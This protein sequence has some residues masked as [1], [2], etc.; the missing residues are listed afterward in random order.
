MEKCPA[1][2]RGGGEL[3]PWV[4]LCGSHHSGVGARWP[5]FCCRMLGYS[6]T[7]TTPVP[8]VADSLI[9]PPSGGPPCCLNFS[10]GMKGEEGL[11]IHCQ[12][13]KWRPVLLGSS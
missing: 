11:R 5:V 7:R 4:P 13:G 2:G 12:M 8:A 10:L 9:Q 3:W 6:N 1:P